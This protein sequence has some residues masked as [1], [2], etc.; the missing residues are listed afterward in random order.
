VADFLLAGNTWRGGG[1]FFLTEH[2]EHF[3]THYYRSRWPPA[4]LGQGLR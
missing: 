3:G 4:G 1:M 2:L